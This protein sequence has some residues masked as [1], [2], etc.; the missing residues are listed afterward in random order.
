MRALVVYDST[1]SNTERIARA[2]ANGIGEG[3]EACRVGTPEAKR[4][5]RVELLVLG[6][7]VQGG[8]PTPAMQAFMDG[9]APGVAKSFAVATFDTRMTMW[10]A[11]LFGYAAVRMA[12]VMRGKGSTL[13]ADPQGF[14]V[15]GRSGPLAPGEI[16]RATQWGALLA[17]PAGTTP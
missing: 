10:I 13:K 7:P 11:R 12:A 1:W 4:L 3:A 8:R 15:K 17:R 6:S 2:I 14:I 5:D 16:E 9:I